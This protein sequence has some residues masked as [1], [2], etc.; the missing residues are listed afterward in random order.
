M[1]IKKYIHNPHVLL[2]KLKQQ[3]D[4]DAEFST[5]IE[6]IEFHNLPAEIDA[7]AVKSFVKQWAE[8][9]TDQE[10]IEEQQELSEKKKLFLQIAKAFKPAA[11]E[12]ILKPEALAKLQE[13]NNE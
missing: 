2:K 3:F 6:D 10:E 8:T 11:L 5:T 7:D 9:K 4:F 13:W 1:K 12:Q